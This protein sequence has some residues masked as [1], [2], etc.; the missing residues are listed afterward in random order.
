MN[1]TINNSCIGCGACESICSDVFEVNDVARVRDECIPG[2][3]DCIKTAAEACP[4][5]AIE[6]Q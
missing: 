3:E 4:V 2:C 6:V 1:V 5:Y